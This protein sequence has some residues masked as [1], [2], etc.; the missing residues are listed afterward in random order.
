M[1][2]QFLLQLQGSKYRSENLSYFVSCLFGPKFL[3]AVF[4]RLNILF[5]KGKGHE[6]DSAMCMSSLI[7]KFKME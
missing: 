5:T 4:W 6:V 1:Q 3:T 7:E 2:Q